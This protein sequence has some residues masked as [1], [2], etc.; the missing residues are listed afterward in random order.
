MA[1][2]AAAGIEHDEE[3][4]ENLHIPVR[5]R[6]QV[7]AGS[8]VFIQCKIGGRDQKR[9]E[10]RETEGAYESEID[11]PEGS[12]EYRF[13]VRSPDNKLRFI[14]ENGYR[15]AEAKPS[16]EPTS[17]QDTNQP[18]VQKVTGEVKQKVAGILHGLRTPEGVEGLES[19]IEQ[20]EDWLE[21]KG[22]T[23]DQRP[24]ILGSLVS[25]MREADWIPAS[26]KHE[27]RDALPAPRSFNE[28]LERLR[29]GSARFRKAI[30]LQLKANKDAREYFG[31]KDLSFDPENPLG[32][33]KYNSI[34]AKLCAEGGDLS[35]SAEYLGVFMEKVSGI[36]ATDPEITDRLRDKQQGYLERLKTQEGGGA[37][38]KVQPKKFGKGVDAI[39]QAA[40]VTGGLATGT[41]LI[42]AAILYAKELL[43]E[44]F[45]VSMDDI[46]R[47]MQHRENKQVR[48]EFSRVLAGNNIASQAWRAQ[49]S[50][51]TVLKTRMKSAFVRAIPG[52]P[53]FMDKRRPKTFSGDLPDAV[54]AP[55]EKAEQ[56]IRAA[57][58][59]AKK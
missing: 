16:D 46:A 26:I 18:K 6:G 9:V 4:G 56:L 5:F 27:F 29:S 53:L 25:I 31:I 13:V 3:S 54:E 42:P 41:I 44:I 39:F 15:T 24:M 22:I 58:E 37:L 11:V 19:L 49:E 43:H 21:M 50:F 40:V 10:L 23:G 8:K 47:L 36:P 12:Y 32:S 20:M 14:P 33:A 48:D 59:A 35:D 1:R 52:A 30:F 17:A 28:W 55:E 45:G 34:F 2:S 57:I 51:W 38:T 7:E